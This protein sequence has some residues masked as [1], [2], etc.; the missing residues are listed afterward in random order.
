M[1][2]HLLWRVYTC[3]SILWIISTYIHQ[4]ECIPVGCILPALVATTRCQ[5][6]GTPGTQDHTPQIVS[7][8]TPSVNRM[9]D[10]CKNITF[11][12]LR[13]RAVKKVKNTSLVETPFDSSCIRV[14]GSK[15]SIHNAFNQINSINSFNILTVT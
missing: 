7:G 15:Y 6:P 14:P 5:Y 3:D 4:Q 12:Q 9:T 8:I 2:L 1:Y 10:T 11:P 13:L